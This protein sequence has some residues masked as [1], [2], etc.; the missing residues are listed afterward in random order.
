MADT[1]PRYTPATIETI[2]PEDFETASIRSAAPSYTSD[3]PSYH[4]T[5]PYPNDPVP[6]YSPPARSTPASPPAPLLSP[7]PGPRHQGLPPVPTGPVNSSI[8]SIAQFR[9]PSW[10]S[11]SSNPTARHYQRV[12]HRRV[13]AATS[14]SNTASADGLRRLMLD[15]IEEEERNRVR[16]L[17]D[18]HLVGEHAAAQARRE[19]LARENGDEI[20]L[21][22]DRRWDWFLTQM[23]EAKEREEREESLRRLRR[24]FGSGPSLGRLAYRI[25]TLGAR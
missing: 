18:P 16:P 24:S 12:A 11:L 19:R 25:G 10:S 2:R 20:L 14:S 7:E 13:A 6:P 9:T 8:P 1:A 23:R 3:A 22:E 5:L 17:E 21:R 4:S 15:Q